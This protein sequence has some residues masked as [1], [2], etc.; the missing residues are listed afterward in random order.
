MKEQTNDMRTPATH[1]PALAL[2][3]KW[4]Q[5]YEEE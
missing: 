5:E 1:V 3:G 4:W 2:A